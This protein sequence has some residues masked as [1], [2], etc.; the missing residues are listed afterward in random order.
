MTINSS[1]SV[2]NEGTVGFSNG[3]SYSTGIQADGG[4]PGLITNTGTISLTETT[5]GDG[6]NQNV[7]NG[8]FANGTDRY[9][10]E[11]VGPGTFTGLR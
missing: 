5:S 7:A 10:I 9:G 4:N 2:T 11:I 6:T 1:N 8:P 3:S